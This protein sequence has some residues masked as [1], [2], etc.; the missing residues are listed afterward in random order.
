M[1]PHSHSATAKHFPLPD[2][3]GCRQ[4]RVSMSSCDPLAIL[5]INGASVQC[6]SRFSSSDRRCTV[7]YMNSE[8]KLVSNQKALFEFLKFDACVLFLGLYASSYFSSSSLQNCFFPPTASNP[9]KT[10]LNERAHM[11]GL[12]FN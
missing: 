3:V 2:D 1:G 4:I 9:S 11:V 6:V 8:L 5:I 10:F 12:T 7:Q